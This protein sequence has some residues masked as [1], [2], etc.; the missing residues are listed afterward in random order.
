MRMGM[1]DFLKPEDK[2]PD[3]QPKKK[4]APPQPKRTIGGGAAPWNPTAEKGAKSSWFAR[5]TNAAQVFHLLFLVVVSLV[6]GLTRID[7]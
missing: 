7:G 1:F 6:T 5:N 3:E 4:A 2:S